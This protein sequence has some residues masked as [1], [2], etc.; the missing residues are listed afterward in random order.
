VFFREVTGEEVLAAAG[1]V[2]VSAEAA[3]VSAAAVLRGVGKM[4]NA[5]TFFTPEEQERIRQT[6]VTAEQRTAGEIVP[7]LVGASAR[8]AEIE[9]AGMGCGLVAGTLASFVFQDPW[10]SIHSQLL[11]PL[12][13]AVVGS[14]LCVIPAVKRNLTPTER[15]TEAVHLRSLAAFTAQGLHY[16]RAHTGILILASL[17]EHRVEVLADRGINEKVAAGTWNEIVQILTAGL[18]SGNACD[19]Y[20]KAIE[21]CGEI[22][23][24]HFPRPP[25]DTDEL[26]NKL[27]IER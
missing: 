13:G 19:A 4:I 20:C 26:A 1:V 17:L 11:W 6:V 10:A 8:Y 18:K 25:D 5:E 22:L 7:M 27:V 21:R 9:M 24:Q 3:A 16:T 12:A 2:A 15:I 14:I 23:A